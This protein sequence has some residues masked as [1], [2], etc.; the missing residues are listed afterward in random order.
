MLQ[1]SQAAA[2][3]VTQGLRDTLQPAMAATQA[4]MCMLPE[5][6]PRDSDAP[7]RQADRQGLQQQPGCGALILYTSG[8]TGQPKGARASH[9][10]TGLPPGAWG[11]AGWLHDEHTRFQHGCEALC[12]IGILLRRACSPPTRWPRTL[13]LDIRA[14]RP[15][16]AWQPCL[17]QVHQ[18]ARRALT[19]CGPPQ[20]SCTRTG[21]WA[22]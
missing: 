12:T 18:S 5:P 7:I 4:G 10:L 11:A 19:A 6:Q 13:A 3:L 17:A 14:C 9:C 15:L 1:D 20:A 2:A 8:T 22:P 21:G 16:D